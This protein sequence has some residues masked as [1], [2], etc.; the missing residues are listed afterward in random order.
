[1]WQSGFRRQNC[2]QP[3]WAGISRHQSGFISSFDQLF[4]SFK[5]AFISAK[6]ATMTCFLFFRRH[7][8]LRIKMSHLLPPSSGYSAVSV[9]EGVPGAGLLPPPHGPGG[10]F[11][12]AGTDDA[13]SLGQHHGPRE[14]DPVSPGVCHRPQVSAGARVSSSA[15]FL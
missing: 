1:M 15:L 10:A 2:S 6:E 11:P 12:V 14:A 13:F 9:G 7:G 3:W 4:L 5:S 8:S